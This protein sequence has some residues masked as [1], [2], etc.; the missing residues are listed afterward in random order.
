VYGAYAM[1]IARNTFAQ[2]LDPGL[3]KIFHEVH[4]QDFA[5]IHTPEPQRFIPYY[6][7][8][9][10]DNTAH[11][12]A[13]LYGKDDQTRIEHTIHQIALYDDASRRNALRVLAQKWNAAARLLGISVVPATYA[14]LLLHHK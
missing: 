4:T 5:N 12:Y 14:D 13:D 11:L 10:F 2:L 9:D 6:V 8:D 3:Q 7:A 1:G